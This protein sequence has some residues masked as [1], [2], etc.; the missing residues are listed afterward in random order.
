MSN[1]IVKFAL[2]KIQTLQ[3]ALLKDN[4]KEGISAEIKAGLGFGLDK[5]NRIIQVKFSMVFENEKLPFIIAEV[6][7][8]FEIAPDS[9]A[10]FKVVDD[11]KIVIPCGLVKHLSVLTVG[12]ARGVLHA[13][14]ENTEFNKFLLPTI[15]V[16]EMIRE[17]LTF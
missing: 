8:F 15:N 14:T 10:E 1:E 3:F 9:F 5:E 11:G 6:A 13:K 12:T 4:C 17:D 16:Q 2:K 7:C